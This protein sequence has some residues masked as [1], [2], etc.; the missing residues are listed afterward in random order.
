MSIHKEVAERTT[1]KRQAVWD[2]DTAWLRH[3][4]MLSKLNR[5]IDLLEAQKRGSAQ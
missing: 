1:R 4:E 2:R 5:I 3:K